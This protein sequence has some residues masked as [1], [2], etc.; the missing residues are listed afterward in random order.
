MSTSQSCDYFLF[1]SDDSSNAK[2][3]ARCSLDDSWLDVAGGGQAA[4]RRKSFIAD[5][6]L[7]RAET[8]GL[9][10]APLGFQHHWYYESLRQ[11]GN[12][13]WGELPDVAK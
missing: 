3:R 1:A 8:A 12:I 7:D 9:A 10:N 5:I 13:D 2:Y 6:P 11:F 4:F